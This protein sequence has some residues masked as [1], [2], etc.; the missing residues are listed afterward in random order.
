MYKFILIDD[1]SLTRKGTL[2]KLAPLSNE[3]T[4]VGEASDGEE[5]LALIE[6]VKPDIVITDMKMPVMD[7]VALLPV[8]AERYPDLSLIV[9]SGYKDFEYMRQ[10][11]HAKAI[12][13]LLKPF[14][15]EELV[16]VMKKAVSQRKA[17]KSHSSEPVFSKTPAA[18]DSGS[19]GLTANEQEL[20]LHYDLQLLQSMIEG[21]L[22]DTVPFINREI[23]Q[24]FQN[25]RFLLCTLYS[26]QKIVQEELR[27]FL[28]DHSYT[29]FLLYLPHSRAENLGYLVITLS[30]DGFTDPA[31]HSRRILRSVSSL[32][33]QKRQDILFGCSQCH[34]HAN[35]LHN[36]YLETVQAMNQYHPNL[37]ETLFFYTGEQKVP[38]RI[39][40]PETNDLI[41]HIE[42]GK[43]ERTREL[44]LDLFSYYRSIRDLTLED[45]KFNCYHISNQVRFVIS[46]TIPELQITREESNLRTAL[47]QIFGIEELQNYYLTLWTN[48]AANL[49]TANV[50]GDE[51]LIQNVKTYIEHYYQKPIS[52]ELAATLFHVNRSYLSHA[53]KK[54]AGKSFIDYL[55]EV[56]ISHASELLLNS[57]K[58][59]SQIALLSGYNNARYFFR[60]FKKV[61]GLT[62]EQYRQV[63]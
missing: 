2:E 44:V 19:K 53:F 25:R 17:Q 35:E 59:M 4:C 42:S 29:E 54:K 11:L 18:T 13:Y 41:F 23:R 37:S 56:R 58:K 16:A 50:Y 34:E 36:A 22:P 30:P 39:P 55:N 62:P 31:G 47:N 57:D 26:S 10:A 14:S 15:S 9:I 38:K 51:D 46:N 5:G 27:F 33:L 63:H 52:V 32:F 1:E 28:R 8:L 12:D 61:K 48:L 24:R 7:G 49:R 40:W 3:I 21:Y 60:A 43:T 45:I 6:S 20:Q